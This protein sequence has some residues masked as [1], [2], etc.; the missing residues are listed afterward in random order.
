MKELNIRRL[1]VIVYLALFLSLFYVTLVTY[2]LSSGNYI[3]ILFGFCKFGY[4][5]VAIGYAVI[6]LLLMFIKNKKVLRI[7]VFVLLWIVVL[8]CVENI[9]PIG[10]GLVCATHWHWVDRQLFISYIPPFF[11][12]LLFFTYYKYKEKQDCKKK[13][14]ESETN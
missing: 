9:I 2:Y 1:T 12:K 10:F 11:I 6:L 7:I 4:L 13:Q 8:F 14:I 5:E 3:S